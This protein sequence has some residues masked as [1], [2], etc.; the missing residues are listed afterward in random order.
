[1]QGADWCGLADTL[2]VLFIYEIILLLEY[3]VA[4]LIVFRSAGR[5]SGSSRGFLLM[6]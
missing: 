6:G 3:G 4:F 1:V 5:G 2:G